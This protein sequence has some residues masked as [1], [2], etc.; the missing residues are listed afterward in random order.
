MQPQTSSST[1]SLSTLNSPQISAIKR[2]DRNISTQQQT[3]PPLFIPKYKEYRNADSNPP[4][5][6]SS[7]QEISATRPDASVGSFASLSQSYENPNEGILYHSPEGRV[8][9]SYKQS[10]RNQTS[11]HLI[12]DV[13]PC[14]QMYYSPLY[15]RFH[16]DTQKE[17]IQNKKCIQRKG[18]TRKLSSPESQKPRHTYRALRNPQKECILYSTT[19]MAESS[20]LVPWNQNCANTMPYTLARSCS[21]KI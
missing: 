11:H 1:I 2:K 18:K 3:L 9:I 6:K 21:S 13:H 19:F 12:T 16:F 10:Y 20:Q 5:A 17:S 7:D 8:K 14:L 4:P 15:L